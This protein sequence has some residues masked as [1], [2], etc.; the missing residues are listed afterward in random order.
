MPDASRLNRWVDSCCTRPAAVFGL[1]R[2]GRLLP[3]ADADVVVF[4][5]ERELTLGPDVLHSAIDHSTYD[6]M[7]VRGW[8]RTT[9]AGG[10]VIVH[11]GEQLADVGRGGAAARGQGQRLTGSSE[12][13]AKVLAELVGERPGRPSGRGADP[14]DRVGVPPCPAQRRIHVD[15][16][17]GDAW[18]PRSPLAA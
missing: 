11:D 10:E 4:D 18:S 15:V 2:K 12:R 17:V 9:I 13:P 3:G 5:P 16:G 1:E 7:S 14:F 8:P 6:G